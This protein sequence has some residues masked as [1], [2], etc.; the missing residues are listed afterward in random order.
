MEKLFNLIIS[1]LTY[2][3]TFLM[4]I[5]IFLVIL[6]ILL[7]LSNIG[8]SGEGIDADDLGKG[9]IIKAP[10]T[11]TDPIEGGNFY[12][13]LATQ[14]WKDTGVIV[15]GQ[16]FDGTVGLGLSVSN[17]WY[18]IGLGINEGQECQLEACSNS[19]DSRC[20]MLKDPSVM[21]VANNADNAGCKL[22]NGKGVYMLFA[23]PNSE[24][25]YN[26]PNLNYG[27]AAYPSL[28]AGFY[29]AHLGAFPPKE[30]NILVTQAWSCTS[31]GEC[32][33]KPI[34]ELVG[35]KVFLKVV[36]DFYPDNQTK[37][38]NNQVKINIKTGIYRPGFIITSI[39]ALD[40]TILTAVK[41]IQSTLLMNLQGLISTVLILYILFSAISFAIGSLNITYTEL[42][43]RI[44]KLSIVTILTT[45]N[46]YITETFTSSFRILAEAASNLIAEAIPNLAALQ[47]NTESKNFGKIRYLIAY[48]DIIN[49]ITSYQVHIKIISLL[50]TIYFWL[51]PFLY[52]LILILLLIV[53]KALLL[54]ITAYVQLAILIGIL[55]IAVLALLFQLTNEIFQN[56]L[57]Y[58]AN[59]ALLITVTVLGIGLSLSM[60][61]GGLEDLLSY[62]VEIVEIFWY[63]NLS[64]V[65][66]ILT[67]SN[68]FLL[69]I[70]ALL[71][72]AV[73]DYIP[74]L[75]DAF[76]N[77]QFAPTASNVAALQRGMTQTGQEF[78][79]NVKSANNRYGLGRVWNKLGHDQD[80]KG[81]FMSKILD[82]KDRDKARIDNFYEGIT[83][84]YQQLQ[85][86]QQDDSLISLT[87]QF[88]QQALKRAKTLERTELNYNQYALKLQEKRYDY[89]KSNTKSVN[90]TINPGTKKAQSMTIN[91]EGLDLQSNVDGK[92]VD[93]T[94]TIHDKTYK[95]KDLYDSIAKNQNSI[96]N[97]KISDIKY[98]DPANPAGRDTPADDKI[99]EAKKLQDR[100]QTITRKRLS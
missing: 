7:S 29:T 50:F 5:G 91:L 22:S 62:K 33:A 60:I 59:S 51:I 39:E 15:V 18:P 65:S 70:K 11:M 66:N 82:R 69:L 100:L 96:D 52:L 10:V 95:V 30:G 56:W 16:N 86:L 81:G 26:N 61:A 45:P 78:W 44:I 49:Q 83:S 72:Y 23:Q 38:N 3:A 24:G 32:T 37:T 57:R 88:D 9:A 98:V 84:R 21:V 13:K 4:G 54:F 42:I 17:P 36:D 46:S 77:A 58:M 90:F 2:C 35:S 80:G 99:V 87:N 20:K 68:Y 73:L 6:F 97:M 48:E 75:V 92:I 71:C 31:F 19:S 93:S 64:Q 89:L 8:G 47:N 85:V 76:T 27:S 53:L 28:K 12:R 34:K 1:F 94:V 79:K 74:G 41:T 67:A 14:S 25:K 40:S 43:V 63:P 55:P